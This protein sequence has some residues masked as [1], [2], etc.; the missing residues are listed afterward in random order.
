MVK[1]G[2]KKRVSPAAAVKLS[3]SQLASKPE[4]FIR[5]LKTSGPAVLTENEIEDKRSM[6]IKFVDSV[7]VGQGDVMEVPANLTR[8]GLTELLVS[9]NEELNDLEFS[10]YV[11]FKTESNP[12]ALRH[13]V[14]ESLGK[15]ADVIEADT[16]Q[17]IE[18]V[19]LPRS[20]FNVRPVTRCSNSLKGHSESILVCEFSPNGKLLA[21]AGGD[22]AMRLWETEIGAPFLTL[23]RH[24]SWIQSLKYSPCGQYVATGGMDGRCVAWRPDQKQD[25]S[26]KAH[27]GIVLSRKNVKLGRI[28]SLCW[29]PLHLCGPS[30]H[31]KAPHLAVGDDKGHLVVFDVSKASVVTSHSQHMTGSNKTVT[32]IVWTGTNV[33]FSCGRDG[34]VVAFDMANKV[35]VNTL[36]RHKHWINSLA[37]NSAHV[38]R[39][40][41]YHAKNMIDPV[42]FNEAVDRAR[43]RYNEFIAQIGSEILASASDDHFIHL[44]TN[45]KDLSQVSRLSGHQQVINHIQFSPNGKFLASASF[46]KTVRLWDGLHG[47]YLSRFRNHVGRVYR[48][49]WA[50]DSRWLVSASQDSTLKLWDTKKGELKED[51]PGACDEIFCLD[52]SVDGKYVSSGGRD[53]MVRIWKH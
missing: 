12:Q 5:S 9:A 35:V 24:K 23:K 33:I 19:Y 7:G 41:A 32:D 8:D 17:V 48:V 39:C 16:E 28:T 15:A 27:S 37:L 21:T 43:D 44:Y 45:L 52:W 38:L 6:L 26:A 34:T 4:S 11:S 18:V 53:K 22:C 29:Q 3:A 1:R 10:F 50:P 42:T 40:G 20:E 13:E 51:L 14:D 46:D 2:P 36:R 47:R 31:W 30:E 49:S 25:K